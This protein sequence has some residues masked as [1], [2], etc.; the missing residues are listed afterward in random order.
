MTMNPPSALALQ[1]PVAIRESAKLL[2]DRRVLFGEREYAIEYPPQLGRCISGQASIRTQRF[3]LR[4]AQ[5]GV[6]QRHVKE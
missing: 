1:H 4:A 3:F 6:L 5:L 2:D